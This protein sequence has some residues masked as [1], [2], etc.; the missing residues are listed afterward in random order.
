MSRLLLVENAEVGSEHD[1]A[2]LSGGQQRRGEFLHVFGLDVVARR[3]HSALVDTAEELHHYLVGAVVVHD[4]EFADVTMTLHQV[5]E[6]DYDLGHWSNEDLALTT[7]FSVNDGLQ[8]VR[9]D[10]HT[11]HDYMPSQP[12]WV[13]HA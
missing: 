4:F 5:Q 8:A 11:H 6:A 13:T 10:V 3:D 1:K 7:L 9:Q 2:E 12:F